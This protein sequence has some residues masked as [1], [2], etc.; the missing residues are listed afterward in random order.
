MDPRTAREAA[1]VLS[2]RPLLESLWLMER[3]VQ[4]SKFQAAHRK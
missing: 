2:S 1:R 3:A 4:Q